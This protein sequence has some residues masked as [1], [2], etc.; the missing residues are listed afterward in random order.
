MAATLWAISAEFRAEFLELSLARKND[1]PSR[2]MVAEKTAKVCF[3]W[4]A[5]TPEIEV[6]LVDSLQSADYE[7]QLAALGFVGAGGV[8]H[9]ELKGAALR[10]S[11]VSSFLWLPHVN[12]E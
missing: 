2:P 1:A 5:G 3:H 7:I 8:L 11:C 4:A 9:G 10:H 6:L 12:L